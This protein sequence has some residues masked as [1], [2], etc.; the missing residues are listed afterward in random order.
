M[1]KRVVVEVTDDLDGSPADEKVHFGIDGSTYEID[2]T[3]A[4]ASELRDTLA[5]YVAFARRESR[6][7]PTATQVPTEVDPAA[8]RAWARANGIELSPRGRIP[9][10]V[11]ESFRR[12]GN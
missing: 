1:A 11:V 6:A 4:H 8:V 12:A 2:L 3:A 5:T 10:S 7:R 9:A